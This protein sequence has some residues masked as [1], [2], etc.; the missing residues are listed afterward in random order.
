MHVLAIHMDRARIRFELAADQLQ[1]RS[2][3]CATW[4]HNGRDLA[5]LDIHIDII[6][7][8]TFTPVEAQATDFDQD[9]ILFFNQT[10]NNYVLMT[11]ELLAAIV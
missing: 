8:R 9:V 6:E 4:T 5:T 7:N 2:F 1:Q 11:F 3:T 10:V